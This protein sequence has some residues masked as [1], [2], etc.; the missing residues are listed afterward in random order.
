MMQNRELESALRTLGAQPTD[1][2][3]AMKRKYRALLHRYHPD[4]SAGSTVRNASEAGAAWNASEADAG[5]EEALRAV[6][7]AWETIRKAPPS[8][9]AGLHVETLL[10]N[11]AAFCTR[12]LYGSHDL[13]E[14]QQ[15]DLY[16]RGTDRYNWDP[17]EEDFLLFLKSV[18]QAARGL[19]KEVED[20]CTD[21]E[22]DDW[23]EAYDED[24]VEALGEKIT[25]ERT[26]F[27]LKLFHL[28]AQEY[29]SPLRCL[30][31]L[32]E[33]KVRQTDGKM[34][35]E[36]SARMNVPAGKSALAEKNA[37]AGKNRPAGDDQPA[38]DCILDGTRIYAVL[39][40]GTRQQISLE[41]DGCYYPIAMMTARGAA[42][43]Q[44]QPGEL[45]GG[46]RKK[47]QRLRL[48]ILVTDPVTA[49]PEGS[50]RKKI[51]KL[52]KEYRDVLSD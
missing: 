7:N 25:Q 8:A 4:E 1:S 31:Q 49:A 42:A 37:S 43:L 9:F 48:R 38:L 20:A 40:D 34:V 2:P 6:I 17:D 12:V 26:A 16:V 22:T 44:A 15:N 19:L 3:I 47:T 41:E 35:Y 32:A 29:I 24:A 18:N 50:S 36:V 45:P 39:P 21:W 13:F 28:L 46:R 27:Q 30:D 11:P 23:G 33:N 14:E 52:L 10:C 51:E 5:R